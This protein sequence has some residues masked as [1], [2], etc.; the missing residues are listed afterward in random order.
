[1]C[2]LSF[3][4]KARSLNDG[5]SVVVDFGIANASMS[6]YSVAHYQ[7]LGVIADFLSRLK[8]R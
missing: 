4:Q 7:A 5:D 3:G 6:I 8:I 1:M 2:E